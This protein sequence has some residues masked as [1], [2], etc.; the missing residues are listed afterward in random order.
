MADRPF[1][2]AAERLYEKLRDAEDREMVEPTTA[3]FMEH[4]AERVTKAI[5]TSTRQH[6]M[7]CSYSAQDAPCRCGYKRMT[8][9]EIAAEV[10]RMLEQERT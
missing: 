1:Q 10:E 6:K 3:R 4:M 8:N 2:K 5:R 7:Y 9:A